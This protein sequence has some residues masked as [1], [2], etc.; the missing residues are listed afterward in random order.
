MN[1]CNSSKPWNE[2]PYSQ[3]IEHQP[4]S[5]NQVTYLSLLLP[6]RAQSIAFNLRA[7]TEQHKNGR[8]LGFFLTN[9]YHYIE[10]TFVKACK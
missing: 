8:F 10:Q 6:K 9:L 1:G 2:P 3:P 5:S 7:D 4:S